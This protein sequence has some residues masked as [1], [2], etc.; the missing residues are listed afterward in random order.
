MKTLLALLATLAILLTTS[1][2]RAD[3]LG[4]SDTNKFLPNDRLLWGPS[5]PGVGNDGA[6]ETPPFNATTTVFHKT[7]SVNQAG[8][9][10]IQRAGGPNF[11]M[12]HF[13]TNDFVFYT[14]ANATSGVTITFTSGPVAAFGLRIQAH[15]TNGFTARIQA[16]RQNGT[17]YGGNGTFSVNGSNY[18]PEPANTQ[19]NDVNF[20]DTLNNPSG[21]RG[22]PYIGV[23]SFQSGQSGPLAAN[24][25]GVNVTLTSAGFGVGNP[26]DFYIGA[27]DLINT[28]EPGSLTL[29][30]LGASGFLGYLWRRR[31]QR[32]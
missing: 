27:A 29:A 3:F 5:P 21:L 25:F 17:P 8:N 1:Q 23:E 9:G 2:A 26:A 13:A 4:I 28:P 6:N 32:A 7:V 10:Q 22:A 11:A 18:P 16:L 19:D 12:G 20:T 14:E 30:G 15:D 24:I 31:K